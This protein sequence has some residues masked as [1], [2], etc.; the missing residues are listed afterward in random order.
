MASPIDNITQSPKFKSFMKKLVVLG[1]VLTLVGLIMKLRGMSGGATLLIIGMGMLAVVALFLGWLIPC[2]S[3]SGMT[4]W[5]F[6][7]FITGY[8][9]S[10]AI[11]GALFKMMH[12]PGNINLLIV[13]IGGLACSAIAW[14]WYLLYHRKHPDSDN[15][16]EIFED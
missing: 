8:S 15:E 4:I 16:K 13:G 12:W 10:A 7:M 1:A 2:P 6:A 5:K 3:I 11:I 14:L 9:L